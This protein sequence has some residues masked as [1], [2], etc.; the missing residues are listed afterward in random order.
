MRI[1]RIKIENFRQWQ[2]LDLDMS[3]E[4]ADVTVF[5]G[6]NGAGKTN[7]LNSIIWCL[8]NHEDY[9]SR[10][11]EASPLVNQES[12]DAAEDGDTLVC[13]VTLQLALSGGRWAEVTRAQEFVKSGRE[14]TRASAEFK[15]LRH[16]PAKGVVVD[17]NPEH[18]IEKNVPRR[19]EP[20]FLFDGERLDNFFR[21][22]EAQKVSDAVLQIAQIDLLGRLVAHLEKVSAKLYSSAARVNGGGDAEIKGNLLD[23]YRE[24][25][26][27]KQKDVKQ[28][29]VAIE[30]HDSEARRLEAK[31]GNITAV[32][33]DVRRRQELETQ[34]SQVEDHVA[35]SWDELYKWS[36]SAAPGILAYPALHQLRTT[37]DDARSQRRL[38]PPVAPDILEELLSKQECVCGESLAD[39]SS[40]RSR[41]EALLSEYAHIGQLGDLL[42]GLEGGVRETLATVLAAAPTAESVM[43]RIDDWENRATTIGTDLELLNSRLSGHEDSQVQQ[44]EVELS[45]ARRE[46]EKARMEVARE[47]IRAEEFREKIANV[48]KELAELAKRNERLAGAMREAEFSKAC[49]DAARGLY[50]SLTTAVREKVESTL[51]RNFME[52]IWKEG[53]IQSVTINESYGVSVRNTRGYEILPD[54]AAGERECLALAFSL[55]LSEVSG[56][57]LPMVIDTPMGKLNPD[58][59]EFVAGVLSRSTAAR[60]TPE[61]LEPAHQLVL[62]MTETE[63]NP[64]VAAVLAGRNPAVY[65][66]CFDT[67]RC[68]SSLEEVK[69]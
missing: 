36:I 61:G 68:V 25:L 10:D 1:E 14:G 58:V 9:Y 38:P 53:F 7:L 21:H 69:S 20:Y 4:R 46:L 37:I 15:V 49:L 29:R 5:V 54:L 8:Y 19:L 18:W 62:L 32:A 11:M 42:L 39:G 2:T 13:S 26:E 66:I 48:E 40:A 65:R 44:L 50:A 51:E 55:A 60:E 28:L 12:L 63:Y 67:Q 33:A 43:K 34:F 22:A 23:Q 31:V 24:R 6:S 17:A 56:Y 57:E 3:D 45:R 41:I 59:Q 16:D 35:E 27:A 30:A 64:N 47:E 52:M